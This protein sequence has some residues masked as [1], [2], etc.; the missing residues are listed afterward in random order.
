MV[1]KI[2]KTQRLTNCLTSQSVSMLMLAGWLIASSRP[3]TILIGGRSSTVR[4]WVLA[5]ADGAAQVCE[6]RRRHRS[7]LPSLF[8]Q[9]HGWVNTHERHC[10]TPPPENAVERLLLVSEDPGSLARSARL[11][12]EASSLDVEELY[13]LLALVLPLPL[14]DVLCRYFTIHLLPV[15]PPDSIGLL[16]VFIIT[17]IYII[18]FICDFPWVKHVHIWTYVCWT[19]S[20][21]CV[22]LS[23]SH[24]CA[25]ACGFKAFKEHLQ[26]Q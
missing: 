8:P 5:V 16:H 19:S 4:R 24:S 2:K 10:P 21:L 13:R 11:R 20:Q 1:W 15:T 26:P 25:A 18:I 23:K 3:V 14:V 17:C 6:T 12:A 9:I 22:I 7:V